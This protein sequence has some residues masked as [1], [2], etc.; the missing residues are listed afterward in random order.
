MTGHWIYG[1]IRDLLKLSALFPAN[2]IIGNKCC[3][4]LTAVIYEVMRL[5][6]GRSIGPSHA[7]IMIKAVQYKFAAL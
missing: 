3:W 4:I 6:L 1:P 7:T 2:F 5:D